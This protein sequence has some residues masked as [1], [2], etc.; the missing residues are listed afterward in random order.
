MLGGGGLVLAQGGTKDFRD[1][2][3]DF[4]GFESVPSGGEGS[5]RSSNGL[6]PLVFQ[7]GFSARS[8]DA[9]TVY[10]ARGGRVIHLALLIFLLLIFIRTVS[11]T[12]FQRS[13]VQSVHAQDVTNIQRVKK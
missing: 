12:L 1:F 3:L 9:F 5:S 8:I 13:L 4:C 6:Q 11:I 2:G 7:L 10:G